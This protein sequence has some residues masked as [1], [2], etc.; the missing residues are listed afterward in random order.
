VD[1]GSTVTRI[2]RS[3]SSR[4]FWRKRSF[5]PGPMLGSYCKRIC[6]IPNRTYTTC[7]R[8]RAAAPRRLT[9]GSCVGPTGITK[10]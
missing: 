3:V 2:S 5:A 6:A 1:M 8:G 9:C 7:S 10:Q 4:K